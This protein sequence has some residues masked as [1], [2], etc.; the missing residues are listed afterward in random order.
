MSLRS[1]ETRVRGHTERL[2]FGF[3]NGAAPAPA[4]AFVTTEPKPRCEVLS[5]CFDATMKV[6]EMFVSQ[7]KSKLTG[8]QSG[9]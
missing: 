6:A 8:D 4:P 5:N 2:D 1:N 3:S 7:V 9:S